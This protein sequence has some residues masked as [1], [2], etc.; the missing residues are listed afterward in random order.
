MCETSVYRMYVCAAALGSAEHTY[1]PTHGSRCPKLS[2]ILPPMI[3]H[4]FLGS[5]W[6]SICGSSKQHQWNQ[7]M[8]RA[9]D[10]CA[11]ILVVLTLVAENNRLCESGYTQEDS[12][13]VLKVSLETG[14][15]ARLINAWS[16]E[17][18]HAGSTSTF[19]MTHPMIQARI[20]RR[21][22]ATR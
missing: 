4:V 8:Q 3:H 20:T 6:R 12:N 21:L 10:V 2:L 17:E 19:Q 13:C 7:R 18:H 14:C 16:L 11:Q 1:M 22:V 15:Q 9:C 5:L